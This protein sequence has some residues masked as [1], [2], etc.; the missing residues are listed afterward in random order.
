METLSTMNIL[1]VSL[2]VLQEAEAAELAAELAAIMECPI[3]GCIAIHGRYK[4]QMNLRGC[5]V[6][7]VRAGCPFS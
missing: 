7:A 4:H 2:V 3:I 1:P 5:P 6:R